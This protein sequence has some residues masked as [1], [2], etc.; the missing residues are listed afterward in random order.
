MSSLI[1]LVL[2]FLLSFSPPA[3]TAQAA[4]IPAITYIVNTNT[5]RF[6]DPKC[7]HASSIKEKNK[8]EYTG[9]RETLIELGYVPC[10]V[11][12]P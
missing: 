10:K 6:H 9:T 8:L 4:T 2:A 11:C 12:D 3:A 1:S 5:D 7:R